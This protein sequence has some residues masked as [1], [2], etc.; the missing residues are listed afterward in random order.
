[1]ADDLVQLGFMSADKVEFDKR[2]GILEPMVF[3]M[4]QA[5]QGGGAANMKDRIM[6][7]YRTKYPNYTDEQ[8]T[9]ALRVEF[10]QQMVGLV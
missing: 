9:E 7:D 2:S 1:L 10:E 6:A 4:K 8:L 5:G 3:F